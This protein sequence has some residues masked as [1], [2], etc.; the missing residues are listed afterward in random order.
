VIETGSRTELLTSLLPRLAAAYRSMPQSKL[1]GKLPDGRSRAQ[2]GHALA[3]ALA[4][5]GQGVEERDQVDPPVWRVLPFDGPFVVGDQIGVTGHDLLR[6]IA[7]VI[8]AAAVAASAAASAAAPT[9]ANAEGDAD[10][11]VDATMTMWTVWAAD[12]VRVPVD[13]LLADALTATKALAQAL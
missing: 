1:L 12:G 13:Q 6:A 5:A 4:V 2:A 9:D 8:T 11:D 3:A 10:V 7:L